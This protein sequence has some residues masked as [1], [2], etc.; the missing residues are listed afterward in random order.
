MA[1]ALTE[2]GLR[3]EKWKGK[4]RWLSDGGSRGAGRLVA[5]VGAVPGGGKRA[6][7]RITFYFSY[8]NGEGKRRFFLIGEYPDVPLRNARIKAGE[9]SGLYQG[10]T[11][12][13]HE[14]FSA[15]KEAEAAT[16]RSEVEA[17][18]TARERARV[19]TLG[20]LL[21]AYTAFLRRSGRQAAGD[22]AGIFRL[23]VMGE[24]I[25]RRRASDLSV[26]EFV[27]VLAK[28]IEAGKGRTAGKL[29]SY[30]RAAY[31]LAIRSKTDP[32][33]P[34]ILRAFGIQENPIASIDA[35]ALSKYNRAR[36]RNL[37]AD[38]LRHFLLRVE[39]MPITAKKDALDLAV[40]LGGQRPIQLLRVTPEDCDLPAGTLTIYDGKGSRREPRPHVL[41]ITKQALPIIQRRLSMRGESPTVFSSDGKRPL[42]SDTV[43]G[44]VAEVS[45]AMVKA[46]EARQGFELRDLRR[47]CETML[48]GLGVSRDIRAQLQS[49]GLS[50]VQQRHYDKYSYMDEKRAALEKW[51]RHLERIITGK[52]AK[53]VAIK[54]AA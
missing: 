35:K 14:H 44:L 40:I 38:E 18:E 45:A 53:V 50:G 17:L 37:S 3:R 20:D 29:R 31:A 52:A 43:S 5:K 51:A 12:D 15:I 49:H 27:P 54:G 4:D 24:A 34:L 26:D 11:V 33:A 2:P 39:E 19:H 28:L 41:P 47:T 8:F 1:N 23:H 30:L 9:L 16:R 36:T 13:L 10:G 25:A 22:V 42:R 32:D 7:T 48:A 21:E 6:D 46:K